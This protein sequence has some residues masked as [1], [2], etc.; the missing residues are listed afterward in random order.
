MENQRMQSLP[1]GSEARFDAQSNA[2]SDVLGRILADFARIGRS[3][4]NGWSIYCGWK[5]AR[6][7]RIPS[8]SGIGL[9]FIARKACV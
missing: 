4:T 2:D 7:W 6:K 9:A 1:A 8:L 3:W 5:N